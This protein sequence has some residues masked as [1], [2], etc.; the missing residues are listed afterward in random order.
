M[1]IRGYETGT[2][3][4]AHSKSYYL[5]IWKQ[6]FFWWIVSSLY[7]WYDMRVEK[8]PF[9]HRFERWHH[10]RAKGDL[11]YVPIYCRRDIRCY[12][13]TKR[14]KITVARIDLPLEKFIEINLAKKEADRER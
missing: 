10:R 1:K 2:I 14:G 9:V 12:H 6:D 7:H 8:I 3:V 13:L 5:E 4:S 11:S